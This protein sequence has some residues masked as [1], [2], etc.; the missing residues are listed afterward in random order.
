MSWDESTAAW[1]GRRLFLAFRE[2]YLARA[3]HNMAMGITMRATFPV[4]LAVLLLTL[5]SSAA[6]AVTRDE[7]VRLSKSGVSDEVILALVDRDK[8]IFTISPDD[9]VALKSEGVSE[10]VVLAMLKSGREE[11]E[12]AFAYQAAQA[13]SERAAALWLAPNVVVIGHGPDR[14]NTG[15]RDGQ[16]VSPRPWPLYDTPWSALS[17]AFVPAIRPSLCVAHVA[18]RPGFAAFKYVTECPPQLPR[19]SGRLPR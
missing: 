11:G 12:A 4:G 10:A 7:I 5:A 13:A 19:R 15:Y 17:G 2:L 1:S 16:H 18:A 14:P 6:S 9:L 3:L 8:T